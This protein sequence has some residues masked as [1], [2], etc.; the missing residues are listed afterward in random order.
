LV[1]ARA[2]SFEEFEHA[3][4]PHRLPRRVRGVRQSMFLLF[5]QCTLRRPLTAEKR[6]A[7]SLLDRIKGFRKQENDELFVHYVDFLKRSETLSDDEVGEFYAIARSL[8]KT[9][10]D[11]YA[12]YSALA[13]YGR[14]VALAAELD[15][16]SEEDQRLS[17]LVRE[18]KEKTDAEIG[19]LHRRH[20]ELV[21]QNEAVGK[22]R[23]R[24]ASANHRAA[25]LILKHWRVLGLPDPALTAPEP[26]DSLLKRSGVNAA[27]PADAKIISSAEVPTPQNLP[28]RV[29]Q[30]TPHTLGGGPVAGPNS[31]VNFIPKGGGSPAAGG[32]QQDSAIKGLG[33]LL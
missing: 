12:D 5:S 27:I 17:G 25:D 31:P 2:C 13:D 9:E 4:F 33:K 1:S 21:N 32:D 15:K 23:M 26:L 10:F 24:A 6:M 14:E 8:D 29:E 28:T 30:T 16:W 7:M 3:Q 19:Q 20:N 22:K 11:M 18:S